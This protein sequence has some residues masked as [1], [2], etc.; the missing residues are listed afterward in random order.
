MFKANECAIK[1]NE[2]QDAAF[3][4]N[5]INYQGKSK[6]KARLDPLF[7]A[8]ECA[9]KQ[10]ERQDAAFKANE[11]NYQGKSK[12]KARLDSLSKANEC[13]IKQN[14]IQDAPFKANEINFKDKSK[15]KAR[16]TPSFKANEI[17]YQCESKQR[18]RKDPS[19]QLNQ[20]RYLRISKQ[21][22]RKRPFVL[23]C[24]RTRKQQKRRLGQ[25]SKE[26]NEL[27]KQSKMK[28]E[29]TLHSPESYKSYQKRLNTIDDC[30]KEFHAS[31]FVG[32]LH[33]CT[34]CHQTWFHA[35][36]NPHTNKNS[37]IILHKNYIC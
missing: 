33:V 35:K 24:E 31:I 5:E 34:C 6:R 17:K 23:E 13:A 27:N 28:V 8:N 25:K 7:K 9:I 26:E 1:Q 22:A 2:R 37:E 14:E 3:K 10:N 11:I 4:A 15:R 29:E 20:A 12:R 18:A 19:F 32:P 21:N 30:I 16:Q 36:E